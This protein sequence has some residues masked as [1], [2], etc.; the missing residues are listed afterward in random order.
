MRFFENGPFIPDDLLIARDE[1]R[2]VFFCGAGV[3]ACARLPDFYGLAESVLEKLRVPSEHL[4]RKV[5]AE[6]REIGERTGASGLISADRIFGLLEREF[7]VEDIGEKVAKTLKPKDDADLSSHRIMLD[8]ATTPEGHIRLVTTNFD[9]LFEAA[10]PEP[11]HIFQPPYLPNL[12][13]TDEFNGVIHLHGIAGKSYDRAEGDGFILSS[14]AFGRAYL[15]E[16]W[17]TQFFRDILEKYTVVFVG[18]GAND[19]P[20]QYLL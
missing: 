3:S 11:L 5:L 14:S 13:R 18:Y 6:A 16:G 20:V 9:R 15:A 12:A 2:V 7:S 17:A 19:P 10:Y 4:T 1:G 8:L